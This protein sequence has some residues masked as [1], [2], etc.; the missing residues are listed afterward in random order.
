MSTPSASPL[1]Q[2]RAML[3]PSFDLHS[4]CPRGCHA[5][6]SLVPRCGPSFS[7]TGGRRGP[8]LVTWFR[9]APADIGR[10]AQRTLP[11]QALGSSSV[12][13]GAPVDRRLDDRVPAAS[14]PCR[15]ANRSLPPLPPLPIPTGCAQG[16]TIRPSSLSVGVSDLAPHQCKL[17]LQ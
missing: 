13:R 16:G 7:R 4:A 12:Q 1:A 2:V 15:A 8:P 14:A 3:A 6:C 5:S 17:R 10:V 9:S 11:T